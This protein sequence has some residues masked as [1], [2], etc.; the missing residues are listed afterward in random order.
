MT[1]EE[2]ESSGEPMRIAE[3]VPPHRLVVETSPGDMQ[4]RM[5]I[6]LAR[7]GDRTELVF[8][9]WFPAG[10]PV[11][12]FAGGWHWYLDKLDTEVSGRPAPAEWEAFWAEVGPVYGTAPDAG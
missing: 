12:D 6:D 2:G 11:G 10:T 1:F 8:R 5:E 9:Q 4:W 3:C 7:V